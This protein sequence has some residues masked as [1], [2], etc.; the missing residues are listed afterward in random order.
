MEASPLKPACF[1]RNCWGEN[2][3]FVNAAS[4]MLYMLTEAAPTWPH[5]P[6]STFLMFHLRAEGLKWSLACGLMTTSLDEREHVT[7]TS[8]LVCRALWLLSNI[9]SASSP[10]DTQQPYKAG[11][12]VGRGSW[13]LHSSLCCRQL[14]LFAL[15][16]TM[17]YRSL[18]ASQTFLN[19]TKYI[20]HSAWVR[21]HIQSQ[22]KLLSSE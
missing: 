16:L 11:T 1:Y 2:T 3:H 5:F 4:R 19:A 8:G 9:M 20:C 14:R 22:W 21:Q 7:H 12:Q 17:R 10:E 18:R 15:Y 6:L 13:T